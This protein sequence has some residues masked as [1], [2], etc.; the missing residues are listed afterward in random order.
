MFEFIFESTRFVDM[1]I[2]FA[3]VKVVNIL[4]NAKLLVHAG[5]GGSVALIVFNSKI[6][7]CCS[8]R[9]THSKE[10]LEDTMM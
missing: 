2:F 6:L 8:P 9:A 5:I 4:I 10:L 7:I 3:C 1:R